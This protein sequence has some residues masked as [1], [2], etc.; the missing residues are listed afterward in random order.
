MTF[1][2][3][4][5]ES[6]KNH[7]GAFQRPSDI[8]GTPFQVKILLLRWSKRAHYFNISFLV[9]HCRLIPVCATNQVLQIRWRLSSMR[10]CSTSCFPVN[11]SHQRIS[12]ITSTV[13]SVTVKLSAGM[14]I[15]Q[16]QQGAQLIRAQQ[17]GGR[18]ITALGICAC[19]IY[20]IHNTKC[21]IRAPYFHL[22]FLYF[23]TDNMLHQA[24]ELL[25][26]PWNT[27]GN[28][29]KNK[30]EIYDLTRPSANQFLLLVLRKLK[31]IEQDKAC[32][33]IMYD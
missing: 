1:R 15:P 27:V 5:E 12:S 20:Q 28:S 13:L 33:Q 29:K 19:S 18:L 7:A 10:N 4:L 17:D 3:Q 31:K 21:G 32:P 24:N 9:K 25:W 6:L 26:L 11:S 16:S 30:K 8:S 23:L 2:S 22:P 14:R